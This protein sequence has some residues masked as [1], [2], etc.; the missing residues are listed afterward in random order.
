[1]QLNQSKNSVSKSRFA[2]KLALAATALVGTAIHAQENDAEWDFSASAFAYSEIDRVSAAELIFT[3]EKDFSDTSNFSFKVVLD[4]LTGASANGAIAQAT[5]QTFTRV[6]ANGQYAIAA[7]ETPTDNNYRDTRAQVNVSWTDALTEDT[8][9]TV[10]SNLS[11]EIDYLSFGVSGELA[12][13]FD[14]R[15]TTLSAGV[16]LGVDRFAPLG[17]VPL[18]F[19]SM[20][21]DNGQ[22]ASNAEF[23]TAF[24]ATR[25]TESET[26]NTAE[27]L[28]GWTQVV[29]R[30]MLFQFN[31]GFANISGYLTDPYKILSLVDNSGISQDYIYEN[32]PD[33]KQQHSVFGL[34]KYHL[35]ESIF[36]VSY[37][38]VSNDWDI[39]SHTIDTHWRFFSDNGS[40]WEPHVRFYQQSAAEFYTPF[41]SQAQLS[42]PAPGPEFASADYRIGDLTA[43]TIGL[44][45][46][47]QLEDGDRA[48]VR[49]EYYKQTPNDANRPSG[50]ANL[51]N[52]D[53]YPEVDA[54]ILQF[55]YF[56]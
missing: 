9:Y 4:S 52:I 19:A 51:E 24:D 35:D 33:S 47:F 6:S 8:R 26:I 36:D 32:R 50:I 14:R 30:R 49:L 34:M 46:G 44:K 37:R 20:V 56:F 48:E 43:Y 40:F 29:N 23:Q 54:V 16:S 12:K 18:A 55:N 13:D 15:N 41:L 31:Y 7:F 3:G 38:Y 25:T 53:L 22:F 28:L 42:L 45:Y 21:V 27:L 11:K 39:Q 17:N 10:G 1:M 2:E 5:P